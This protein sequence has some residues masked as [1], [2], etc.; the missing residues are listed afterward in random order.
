VGLPQS[1]EFRFFVTETQEGSLESMNSNQPRSRVVL[2]DTV[3]LRRGHPIIPSDDA[4][5]TP[6]LANK[7]FDDRLSELLWGQ[8]R[9]LGPLNAVRCSNL[10]YGLWQGL[11]CAARQSG[12][13]VQGGMCRLPC[14]SFS[15]RLSCSH[16]S[17]SGQMYACGMHAG[18]AIR[19][20][21]P[22][23]FSSHSLRIAA[24]SRFAD[25]IGREHQRHERTFN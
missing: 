4:M 25:R 20:Q 7:S 1:P 14:R 11:R 17:G 23:D 21:V 10:S 22:V 15:D 9:R 19:V 5:K 6:V 13:I 2:T 18:A 8:Q 3:L 16:S 12:D 24:M